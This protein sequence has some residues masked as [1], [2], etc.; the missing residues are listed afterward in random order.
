MTRWNAILAAGVAGL[1]IGCAGGCSQATDFGRS[2]R[3]PLGTVVNI[4]AVLV[5]KGL[6]KEQRDHDLT[7]IFGENMPSGISAEG[8][9][10]ITYRDLARAGDDAVVSV[11]LDGKGQLVAVDGK[12]RSNSRTFELGVYK[13]GRFVGEYWCDHT[14]QAPTFTPTASSDG[15]IGREMLLATFDTGGCVG[16]WVKHVLDTEMGDK[17]VDE[18]LI[19]LR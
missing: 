16:R 10:R 6:G 3:A 11:Y 12:F 13:I 4:D 1:L 8:G 15:F 14:R 19:R 7:A 9:K 2:E 17:I 18:M 5:G